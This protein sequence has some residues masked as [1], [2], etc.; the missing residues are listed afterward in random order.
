[1]FNDWNPLRT[2][3]AIANTTKACAFQ[4]GDALLFSYLSLVLVDTDGLQQAWSNTKTSQEGRQHGL[5]S[6]RGGRGGDGI[7]DGIEQ[8]LEDRDATAM[9]DSI[10]GSLGEGGEAFCNFCLAP[11]ETDGQWQTQMG[12][13]RSEQIRWGCAMLRL[14]GT[15]PSQTDRKQVANIRRTQHN[16]SS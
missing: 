4:Q 7:I 6:R 16:S 8:R 13:G 15:E 12:N 11:A 14:M 2:Y 9:V 5:R 1:M 10:L 3:V